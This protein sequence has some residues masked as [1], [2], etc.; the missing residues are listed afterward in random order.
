MSKI[1]K[2]FTYKGFECVILGQARGHRCGYVKIPDGH[3]L[4]Q[5]SS[6]KKLNLLDQLR[7]HGGITYSEVSQYY[8]I[9][10]D[11]IAWWIGFDCAHAFDGTDRALVEELNA[12]PELVFIND[13]PDSTVKDTAVVEAELPDLVDQLEEMT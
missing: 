9:E 12:T 10:A 5:G 6:L 4:F 2:V 13:L 1:E 11:E 8:S 3:P 7:V